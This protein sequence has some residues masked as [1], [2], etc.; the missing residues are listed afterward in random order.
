MKQRCAV[1]LHG[2]ID[3]YRCLNA[4]RNAIRNAD[5]QKFWDGQAI[6]LKEVARAKKPWL[7]LQNP[8]HDEGRPKGTHYKRCKQKLVAN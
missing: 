1:W 8:V 3:E 7:G 4:I 5:I 2:D 6:M